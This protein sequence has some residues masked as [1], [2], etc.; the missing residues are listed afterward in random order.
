[1]LQFQSSTTPSETKTTLWPV[2]SV[3]VLCLSPTAKSW[4]STKKSSTCT[5]RPTPYEANTLT[6]VTV[7]LHKVPEGRH[8]ADWF[9]N[10]LF[11]NGAPSRQQLLIATTAWSE[12]MLKM[13]W[14]SL[15]R[16]FDTRRTNNHFPS[17]C[18]FWRF[19]NGIWRN[20]ITIWPAWEGN[21]W[22]RD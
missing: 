14:T 17:T 13:F 9:L 8:S 16:V 4:S 5:L 21:D 18:A 3:R 15:H 22:L 11:T 2:H 10:D 7:P 1:M 6:N 12:E 19:I 20:H